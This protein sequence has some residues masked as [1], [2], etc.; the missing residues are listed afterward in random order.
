MTFNKIYE[1]FIDGF[2]QDDDYIEIFKNPN[3]SEL[4]EL[5]SARGWISPE[6]DLYFVKKLRIKGS[7]YLIHYDIVKILYNKKIQNTLNPSDELDYYSTMNSTSPDIVGITVQLGRD[8]NL[9]LSES[10]KKNIFKLDTKDDADKVWKSS[11]KKNPGI[12]F[13]KIKI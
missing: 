5:P 7:D 1:E 2:K 8:N 6:G 4:N 13:H 3:K 9:Y 12:K 10:Y 11:E